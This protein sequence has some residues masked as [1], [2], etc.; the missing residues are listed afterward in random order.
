VASRFTLVTSS[1]PATIAPYAGCFVQTHV[2]ALKR[3]GFHVDV[4]RPGPADPVLGD[5]ADA[6]HQVPIR[7][8]N[9]GSFLRQGFP[10]A[11]ARNPLSATWDFMRC[12]RGMSRTLAHVGPTSDWLMAHWAV[13]AGLACLQYLRTRTGSSP[14]LITWVHS[15]DVF[16]LERWPGGDALARKLVHQ[17]RLVLAPSRDVADRLASR[18]G[19]D[20]TQIRV[21]HPG[22]E[23]PSQVAPIPDGPLQILYIG[24]LEAIKGVHG[25]FELARRHSNWR[26]VVVGDGTQKAKLQRQV[27]GLDNV[28]L[29]GGL[30]PEAIPEQLASA[31]VLVLP[32]V[33]ASQRTEGLPTV[34]LEAMAAGRPVVA[35]ATGGVAE[36]VDSRVGMLVDPGDIDQ[37]SRALERL[38]GDR[39]A[40]RACGHHARTRVQNYAS[41][42]VA[43]HML[44][45]LNATPQDVV[46]FR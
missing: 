39:D 3:Q 8:R 30:P 40:L 21:L 5:P 7:R 13:P 4:I 38:D 9:P 22:I 35:G 31:H 43:T 12:V 2:R 16:A 34:L 23:Y 46:V 11:F 19:V 27:A 45:Y 15:S 6:I 32:G 1:Y 18:A 37:M 25:L 29:L 20:P 24:R 44:G 26:L 33:A 17:S 41:D 10:E 28:R 36:L 14:Q 42:R